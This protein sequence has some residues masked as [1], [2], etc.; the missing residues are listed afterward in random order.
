MKEVAK[1][2]KELIIISHTYSVIE[3]L[4]K[5]LIVNLKR[6]HQVEARCHESQGSK[7]LRVNP[8][9]FEKDLTSQTCYVIEVLQ[10][11]LIVNLQRED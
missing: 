6:M 3:M 7:L 8:H 4:K 2:Y 5:V 11:V 10:K 9:L 1:N